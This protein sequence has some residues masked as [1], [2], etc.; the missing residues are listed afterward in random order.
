MQFSIFPTEVQNIKLNISKEI[1]LKELSSTI[2]FG[3]SSQ[4]RFNK[5]DKKFAGFVKSEKFDIVL[6]TTNINSFRPRISIIFCEYDNFTELR[7]EYKL[8]IIV[9]VFLT[10]F[11]SIL[12]LVQSLILFFNFDEIIDD[13]K[14]DYLF[15]LGMMFF[16]FLLTRMGFYMSTGDSESIIN[17]LLVLIS[18]KYA[19]AKERIKRRR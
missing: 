4:N 10:I 5:S 17:K 3:G 19:P 7:I 16:L 2:D 6:K 1:L 18:N 9:K 13:L 12:T 11:L 8:D 14:F 15:P